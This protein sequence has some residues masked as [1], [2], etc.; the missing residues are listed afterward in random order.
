[1]ACTRLAAVNPGCAIVLPRRT[2]PFS[3]GK[4][5]D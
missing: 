3:S 1:M 5:E 4:I 2:Y